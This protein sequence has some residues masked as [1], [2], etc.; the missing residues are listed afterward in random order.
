MITCIGFAGDPDHALCIP[1]VDRRTKSFSYWDNPEDELLAWN[2][3]RTILQSPAPK[4][5]QNGMY[6]I[7][8]LWRRMGIAPRNST[9]DTMLQA[10]ALQPELPKSLGFL[11][12]IYTNESSWKQMRTEKKIE[13]TKKDD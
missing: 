13:R 2:W 6:D 7:Q 8:W 12:S 3:V 10:H 4:E 1:F 5:A 9:L 11:G